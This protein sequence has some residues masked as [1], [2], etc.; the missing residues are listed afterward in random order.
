MRALTRDETKAAARRL[1]AL[2]GHAGWPFAVS[3]CAP[4]LAGALLI[5]QAAL[6]AETLARAIAQREPLTALWPSVAAIALLMA[7]RAL[8]GFVGEWAGAAAAEKVKR[9]LRETLL[10]SLLARPPGWTAA[11]SSGALASAVV[12]QPEALDG[13]FARFLPAAVQAGL[14]PVAIAAAAFAYD[15]TVG[16]LFLLTAPLIPLFMALVGWGA[17]AASDAQTQAFARLSGHFAD[18]I[19]G[20]LTLRLFGRT[21]A[22]ALQVR[23][24]TE[25]LRLRTLRILRIAFLSSAVLEFFAALGVAGVAL[26]VGLSYLGFID[27]RA[28]PLTLSGGLACLLLAPEVYQPLR[29]LAAHHHDRAQAVAAV[30]EIVRQFEELPESPHAAEPGAVSA[31]AIRTTSPLSLVANGLGLR[32]PDGRD[33]LRDADLRLAAGGRLALVG[34]S[35]AGKTALLDALARLREADGEIRFGGEP[36]RLVPE[37]TL[38]A[39]LAYVRQRPH[40]FAGT[41]AENI[42]FARPSADD[43]AV[44]RA[45]EMACVRDFADPLPEGLATRIGDGGLGL[46]GGEAQRVALARLYLRDPAVI[47][48]DEP[49]AHLDAATEKTVL[50][51]LLA[52]AEGR[53]LFLAT[54]SAVVAKR[55]DGAVRIS[56]QRLIVERTHPIQDIAA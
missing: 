43:A 45:A 2:R 54:H 39:R 12:D 22:E 42:L 8:L 5:G 52:F 32:T 27:L 53:T 47:L 56:G 38:R 37:P 35:G 44:R 26:Y 14:L 17:Q 21:E 28:T 50:D 48:L 20:L 4:L 6:L 3:V 25:E 33:I 11:R 10:T 49:T 1:S 15:V 40:L 24:A 18:R 55:M 31:P 7:A 34:S 16:L 13:F 9:A 30:T 19:R 51:R 23:R 41:I 46:S 29:L 36:L